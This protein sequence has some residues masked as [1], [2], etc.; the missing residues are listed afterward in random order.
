[1][2]ILALFFP[3]LAAYSLPAPLSQ[4]SAAMGRGWLAGSGW[5]EMGVD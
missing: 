1:M 4:S 2:S 5:V 3:L